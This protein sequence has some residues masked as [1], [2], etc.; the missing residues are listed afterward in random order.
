MRSTGIRD[1]DIEG[2]YTRY[3][4]MVLRRC[5][6]L[7]R[8]E[9]AAFDALQEVFLK[10][11]ARREHLRGDHPSSLLYRIATNTC[12]NRI[13]DDRRHDVRQSP[14]V[15]HHLAFFE[16]P[17]KGL[18]AKRL[19]DYVIG[20][21]NDFTRQIAVLYFVDGMTIQEVSATVKL[22]ISGVHKHLAKLRRKI[23]ATGESA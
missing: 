4:P 2:Y 17:E 7:L 18:L 13:R 15:L 3:G 8:D 19:L 21:E 1:I 14:D 22:S 23:R 10:V 11:L 6:S 9:Q 20:R 12:L 16:A 5:R